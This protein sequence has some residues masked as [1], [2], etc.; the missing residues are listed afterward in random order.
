MEFTILTKRFA[1]SFF[2]QPL[3][4]IIAAV[5]AWSQPNISDPSSLNDRL[6]QIG[7]NLAV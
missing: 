1:K 6:G 4:E 5:L 7:I 3:G 2:R